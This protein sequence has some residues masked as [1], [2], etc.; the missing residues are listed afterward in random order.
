MKYVIVEFNNKEK[1]G[2]FLNEYT[3][4][5]LAKAALNLHKQELKQLNQDSK[6]KYE[7]QGVQ[8]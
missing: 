7:I 2:Q 3:S 4:K 8:E 6:V 5:E 1:T